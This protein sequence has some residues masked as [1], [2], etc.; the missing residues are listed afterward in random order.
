MRQISVVLLALFNVLPALLTAQTETFNA[1]S[2][3]AYTEHLSVTIGPR[4]MGSANE[5]TALLWVKNKFAAFG[6]DSAFVLKFTETT[7]RGGMVNTNSGT[8]VGICAVGVGGWQAWIKAG[9][10]VV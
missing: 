8:A 1:D 10:E 4:P 3:Y 7:G 5:Q 6:A 2:A 9:G